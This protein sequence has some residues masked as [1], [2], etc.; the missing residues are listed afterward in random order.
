MGV[1]EIKDEDS[2]VTL[3]RRLLEEL[4]PTMVPKLELIHM[5][6][7]NDFIE[8]KAL[9]FWKDLKEHKLTNH[10]SYE[11]LRED[12]ICEYCWNLHKDALP[13]DII[14][15]RVM[16]HGRYSETSKAEEILQRVKA[17]E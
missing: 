15:R 14:V 16:R 17:R 9:R 4:Y 1:E 11:D 5:R 3:N 2:I 10:K 13:E 6:L 7:E 8:R 12:G